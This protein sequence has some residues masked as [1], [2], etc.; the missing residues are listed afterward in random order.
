MWSIPVG[1]V[2]TIGSPGF[3]I[4]GI[5][6]DPLRPDC[7]FVSD[8]NAIRY[9]NSVSGVVSLIAGSSQSGSTDGTG[10]S[11]AF[12][13]AMGLRCTSDRRSL[14]VCDNGNNSMRLIK[15]ETTND[16]DASTGTA[17]T[18]AVTS[19]VF[20][21]M[22]EPC[23]CVFDPSPACAPDSTLYVSVLNGIK[24]CNTVTG[25]ADDVTLH[26]ATPF[27]PYAI[28]CCPTGVLIV[29][30]AVKHSLYAIDP[31]GGFASRIAGSG[32]VGDAGYHEDNKRKS[33][34]HNKYN[35][36]SDLCVSATQ[37]CIWLADTGNHRIRYINPGDLI[38]IFWERPKSPKK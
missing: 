20:G 10:E 17:V 37:R 36:V 29:A 5:T 26:V 16:T 15:L 31:H 14:Y 11:A 6:T 13:Q 12:N 23:R 3:T 38:P 32:S 22:S 8:G 2:E 1:W 28:D 21:R 35:R 30:C 34:Y 24:R 27:N 33:K 19:T 4:R 18:T 25:T 7:Y 9:L